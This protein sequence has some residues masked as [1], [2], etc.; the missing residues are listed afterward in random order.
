MGKKIANIESILGGIGVSDYFLLKDQFSSSIGI[1]P[2]MPVD[3][4]GDKACGLIRPTAMAKFSGS[5]V[6]ATPL[7]I[8][9]NPKTAVIYVLLSNGRIISYDSSLASETLVGTLTNNIGAG[10]E[11][12]DNALYFARS[13]DIAR[14]APLDGSATLT[15]GFWGTTLG[16]TALVN[17][18]YPSINGVAM[19]NHILHRHIDNKLYFAD[20]VGNQGVLH[21]IKTKKTTVE[22]DTDDGSAYNALDFGYGEWPTAIESIG[23]DLIIALIEGTNTDIIQKPAKLS[24]WDTTSVSF[25]SITSIELADPIISAIRN[26]N[27][28]LYVFSGFATGGCRISKVVSGYSLEEVVWLPEQYPPL[29]GAVD[30]FL[31]RYV[32]GSNTIEPEVSASVFAVGA[33][34]KILAGRMGLHNI[35]RATATGTNPMITAVKYIQQ[36]GR[37]LIP[38]IGWKDAAGAGIDKVSTT[39]GDNNVFR[40][41]VFR[42]G[43]HFK[44]EKIRISFA[45]AIA[46][47]MTLL[48]KIYGDDGTTTPATNRN[49]SKTINNANFPNNERYVDIFPEEEYWNNFFIQLEWSGT[50]LLTVALP[51]EIT[52]DIS[53]I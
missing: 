33:K 20:V 10:A 12:Y 44:I 41:D 3:D 25:T 46:A 34:E 37:I 27:G 18:T 23:T 39:Y 2:D 45:Q 28:V 47:N 49:T 5:N 30:H 9:T 35:A 29:A 31:N 16:K 15:Q 38:I 13:T 36:N 43:R 22:G 40:S 21:Y 14:L 32:F 6:N 17:T 42:I 24:F 7:F 48:V 50:A 8:I 1:D 52:L 19:P 11:Y 53:D 4:S 26:I 51:I